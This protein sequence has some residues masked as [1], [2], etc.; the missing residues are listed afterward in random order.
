MK[1]KVLIWLAISIA[2]TV[3]RFFFL[4]DGVPAPR[5]WTAHPFVILMLCI[6]VGWLKKDVI[7]GQMHKNGMLAEP[8]YVGAGVL[9]TV[10]ALLMPLS[11]DHGLVLFNVVLLFTGLFM[12]FFG[13]AVYLPSLLVFVYGFSVSFP[14]VLDGAFGTQ[15]AL[16]TTKIV[17]Y[18]ASLVYPVVSEGQLLDL[19]D[20]AGLSSRV[21]I[22][23]GCS[24]SASL[25][26]FLTVFA[27][28]LIDTKPRKDRILPLFLFGILGTSVQ[29]IFRLLLLVAANYHFGSAA[30]WKVHDYAGY[31]LFPVWFMV[32]IYVYLKVGVKSEIVMD[33]EAEVLEK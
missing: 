25:A 19:I 11:D 5:Q 13:A 10:M 28:M 31:V 32:F 22:D 12:I 24:G 6:A 29:N 23:A 9:I 8:A 17:A 1:N 14:K 20:S 15:Y 21:F 2:I 26:I 18:V 27:L 3:L 33:H 4:G 16:I 7:C 30:M